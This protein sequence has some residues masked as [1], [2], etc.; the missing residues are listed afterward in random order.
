MSSSER[1]EVRLNLKRLEE[2]HNFLKNP[3]FL[4]L[5]H[6]NGGK[7]LIIPQQKVPKQLPERKIFVH[8]TISTESVPVFLANPP[9]I[10]FTDY[11]VGQIYETNVELQNLTSNSRHV[12]VIPPST[13]FF[14]MGLGKFP[15]VGG[16][17]AP[18]M[19]C[20]Y[21]IRFAPDSSANYEDLLIVETQSH[22][23]LVVPI[24]AKRLPPI[25]TLPRTLD[26]GHCLVGGMKISQFLCKNKGFNS[27]RFCM[28]LKKMWPTTNFRS[29]AASGFLEAPPFAIRP[30]VF[31]LHPGQG[32]ILEVIFFPACCETVSQIITMVCDNCQV[33]DFEITGTGQLVALDFVSVT[34]GESPAAPGECTDMTA[35]HFVRFDTIN[36]QTCS[37]KE[38]IIRNATYVELPYCWQLMK[39]NLQPVI[40][41]EPSKETN[42]E[43]IPDVD[44]AF[45][46]CPDSGVLQP[47]QEHHFVLSYFP[48]ELKDYHGVFYLILR[49]IPEVS[50]ISQPG[51]CARTLTERALRIASTVVNNVIAMEVEVKGYTEPFHVKLEPYAILIPGENYIHTTLKKHFKIRNSSLSAIKYEWDRVNDCHIIEVV[52]SF[53]SIEPNNSHDLQISITGGKPDKITHNLKC[54]IKHQKEPIFLHLEATVLGPHLCIDLPSLDFGLVR[55]RTAMISKILIK[56]P[57]Q[58]SARWHLQESTVCLR[59]RNE[60]VSQFTFK[61]CRGELLP[62]ASCCVTILFKP[63]RCQSLKT[64][65]QLNVENGSTSHL[66]VMA[67]VQEMHVCLMN[68]SLAF[69]VLY[70]GI[71]AQGIATLFNQTQLPVKFHWGKL[72]GKQASEYSATVMPSSGLLGPN[73]QMEVCVEFVAFIMGEVT[74][75]ALLC[76]VE[77]M[78]EPL[79]LQ[80]SGNPMGLKVTYNV[81]NK[82][83]QNSDNLVL[84]FK[85]V[86]VNEPV[87]QRLVMTNDTA[88]PASFSIVV[89]HF[90][91]CF[92]PSIG[93]ESLTARAIRPRT[94]LL[95]KTVNLTKGPSKSK[96]RLESEHLDMMLAHSKGVSFEVNPTTGT[97]GPFQRR[98]IKV[99]AFNNMWGN[100]HDRLVCQV[101]NLD[102][103]YIN[104]ELSIKG[105]PLYF[106]R[107]GAQKDIEKQPPT[108]RFG[109]HTFG[110]DMVS[111]PVDIIN[112]TPFDIRLDW[113]MYNRG[114]PDLHLLDL[115]VSYGEKFPLKDVEGNEFIARKP[116]EIKPVHQVD[117]N[118]I[119]NNSSSSSSALQEDEHEDE[120]EEVEEEEEKEKTF[121]EDLILL[122]LRPHEGVLSDYPYAITPRQVVVP[123]KRSAAVNVSFTPLQLTDLIMEKECDSFAQGFMSLDSE[124]A[125]EIPGKVERMDGYDMQPLHLNLHAFVKPAML[126]LEI[127]D[128][129]MED[130][131]KLV[132]YS[133][134]SDLVPHGMD[135]EI[136][137]EH[138]KLISMKLINSTE[139]PLH[140]KLLVWRPFR[141]IKVD[142]LNKSS[143]NDAS[144]TLVLLAQNYMLVTVGFCT[145]LDMLDQESPDAQ[146]VEVEFIESANKDRYLKYT[147]ELIIEYSNKSSQTIPLYGYVS[148]P[149]FELSCDDIDFG[150][151]LVGQTRIKEVFLINNT[152]SKSFWTASFD[153]SKYYSDRDA[154]EL[155]PRSGMINPRVNSLIST[156]SVL[157]INFTAKDSQEYSINVLVRGLLGEN[158]HTLSVSGSGSYDGRY[159]AF[160]TP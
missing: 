9:I 106:K 143:K 105:V 121:I 82:A 8:K 38:I 94:T 124:D 30:A 141:V 2:R 53:G 55:L 129:D 21:T 12:R 113:E 90:R 33:K 64:V 80:M 126:L 159:E 28:M 48:H 96:R 6:P 107:L 83:N 133:A 24:E 60:A 132:F 116:P 52:P 137:K 41:G 86:L 44:L 111:L 78:K 102:P 74:D 68:C 46:I 32:I 160:C 36:P 15:G 147:Q 151:C 29:V 84:N 146:R 93:T 4:S 152:A 57:C 128:K 77:R 42:I 27:G 16:I 81:L 1:V 13:P 71:P 112:T 19:T 145:A 26:C 127:D 51:P 50:N 40:P 142:L 76:K 119:P 114:L 75:L 138:I 54:T 3:R 11:K 155:S 130:D 139:I 5:Q 149:G 154:F 115:F 66:S 31:E 125:L 92:H 89:E 150:I 70:V 25:L 88:I 98:I 47:L 157:Q 35:E 97:L 135:G 37:Q 153:K 10:S 91:P 69:K 122:T 61:P 49:D 101:G 87:K 14:S 73:K 39:P 58:I 23:P 62:L 18:G 144:K 45:D 85:D 158:P 136:M 65:L 22:F 67:E 109:T 140:F 59:E 56:N 156:R 134:A 104:I 34:G 99:T 120:E 17:V 131:K 7:S 103:A 108:I 110:G 63:Q 148:V 95:K 72:I 118:A 79:L 123:A 43:Y 117:W 100:Y 20:Q